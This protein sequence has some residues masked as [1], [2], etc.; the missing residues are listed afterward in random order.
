MAALDAC[1]K[2]DQLG[3]LGDGANQEDLLKARKFKQLLKQMDSDDEDNYLDR[4]IQNST[5]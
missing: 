5:T 3:L 1:K 2:L 4:T